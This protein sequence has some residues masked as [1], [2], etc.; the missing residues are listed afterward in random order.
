MRFG[1]MYKA[2]SSRILDSPRTSSSKL[3]THL[4]EMQ[5]WGPVRNAVPVDVAT[6]P[7]GEGTRVATKTEADKTLE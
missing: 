7:G 1:Q 6:G 3:G 2:G 5:S 4:L